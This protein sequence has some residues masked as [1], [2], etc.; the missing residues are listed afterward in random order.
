[1]LTRSP[2]AR[3]RTELASRLLQCLSEATVLSL[4]GRL[5]GVGLGLVV[6]ALIARFAQWPTALSFEYVALA[7]LASGSVGVSF[8]LYPARKA[9]QLDP[10]GA[11]RWE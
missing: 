7:F 9:A 10:I 5:I 1:M 2:A 8:G 6:T 3:H 11:L 4:T